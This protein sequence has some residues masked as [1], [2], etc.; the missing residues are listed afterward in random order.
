MPTRKALLFVSVLLP[1]VG[2]GQTITITGGISTYASLTNVT[3]NMSGQCELRVTESN[4]PISGC[5]INLNSPD[6]WL[7]FPNV[8]P[9]VVSTGYLGQVRV[10]GAS[11]VAGSNCRLDQYVMGSVIVPHNPSFRPLTL[12]SGANFTG[13][14]STNFALYTYHTNN[15]LG[16]FNRNIGSFKLKRGYMATFAQNAN[17]TGASR[18]FI[19]QDGDLEVALL[20]AS[21][22]NKPVSFV[23][24]FP[25]RWTA[26]RGWAGGVQP[27]VNPYWNYDWNTGASSTLDTEYA[28]MKWDTNLTWATFSSINSKQASSH[29]LGYNEP[30]KSDQANVPVATAIGQW[31]NFMQSGLRVGAPGVSD[32]SGSGFGKSWLYSFMGQATN[33]GYRVDYVPIHAYCPASSASALMSYLQDAY[34]QTKRPIWLTEFNYQAGWCGGSTPTYEQEATVIGQM[35]DALEAAPY[36]ERYSIYN[37]VG[38]TR[39]MVTSSNTLTPA[40]I[41]YRDKPSN[42]A[43]AQV[44]PEAGHRGIAQLRFEGDTRD[45]SGYLHHGMAAGIPAYT[46]G[47]NGLAVLLE[48]SNSFVQLPASVARSN[49]FSFAAWVRW[50]GGGNWQRIFDFGNDLTHYLFLTP[51]SGSGTLRFAI[52]NGGSE[53]R[54]ET[55][56][57]LAAGQWVHVA[58]TMNGATGALYTNGL[59]A[60]S[61]SVSITPASFS[62]T[63]NYLGKSQ[64]AADPLFSGALDEVQIADYAF[65]TS[66]IRALMTNQPPQFAT[67]FYDLGTATPFVSFGGS[68]AGAASDPDAGDTITYSK[69]T[70]PAWLT[71]SSAGTLSGTPGANDGGTNYFTARATD[72]AGASDFAVLAVYVPITYA[73]GTWTNDGDGDWGEAGNWL[74]GTNANGAGFTANFAAINITADR[75]V[76]LDQSRSIGTLT[77]GDTS[78]AQNWVL[79]SDGSALALD[80][81]SSVSPGIVVNQNTATVALPLDGNNGFTKTGAGTLTLSAANTLSGTIYTDRDN[82]SV[83]DGITRVAHYAALGSVTNI[84]IRNN[85]TGFSRLQ[86]DGSASNITVTAKLNVSCRNNT[87]P[88]IQNVAG[89]NTIAGFV[90]LGVGG[91][92]FN[93]QADS[94]LLVF[95]NTNRYLGDLMGGRS[96]EF[97]GAGDHLVS[98]PILNSTNGAPISLRK[99]GSGTLR[100]NAVNTYTNGT[101]VGG[102]RLL[103]NGTVISNLTVLAGGTLGGTGFVKGPVSVQSG[104]TLAPGDAI[105]NLTISNNLSLAGTALFRLNKT[106]N[107]NDS[108]R[109]TGSVTYGG[110]LAVTNVGGTLVSGDSYR[111]F[112]NGSFAGS[113]G[114][115]NLPPVSP[116]LGWSFN[117][118]NGLLS[119]VTVGPTNPSGLT[120]TAGDAQV[121]L[122]WNALA[123]AASYNVKSAT[124]S[125]GPYSLVANPSATNY[126]HTGLAAGSTYYYVVSGV[127]AGGESG[128]S[129]EA[130]A[131]TWTAFQAWQMAYFGCTNCPQADA[132]ADADGDG[133]DNQAE[134]L[135]GTDPTNTVSAFRVISILPAGDDIVVTWQ[136]GAGKTGA[137][138][139]VDGAYS[140]NFADLSGAI[141]MPGGG[142]TNY[143]DAGAA[144]NT[145]LRFYRVRLVP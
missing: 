5:T 87:V 114:A 12:Y 80:S 106:A 115:M 103:V 86:L 90:Q 134:W 113:F 32:T 110:T 61:G 101:T 83:N 69:A 70:G 71:I 48:G 46:A 17:G 81:G 8:R 34:N 55:A 79:S 104:G 52:A 117:P 53:Q 65:S 24:V 20:S 127:N 97:L 121:A 119:V 22:N 142:V 131:T 43:Y 49:A 50:N 44:V 95:A 123:G 23:R 25:W 40:G 138:Q 21:L 77:F 124:N 135:S 7:L 45:T 28:P 15:V 64:F 122:S 57:A 11:A 76:T 54:V 93:I 42:M 29:A 136:G 26:K 99:W 2:S 4:S 31:P 94:G 14:S 111:L 47:T 105:G 144:T 3:V 109:T 128:N 37:W 85:N 58:F 140:T 78:G 56:G 27:L 16:A 36:V 120:A 88:T 30:D 67:N 68:I 82:S 63:K 116:G 112:N 60:A 35:I 19:A 132:A 91:S 141:V 72:G 89:T 100:L 108:V 102:G 59:L 74:G 51:S 98:G 6:A 126:T 107:T 92:N 1:V 41:L 18:N 66:Q 73:N 33:L 75:T 143:P 13:V 145:L 130:N 96:Y 38:D 84:Q 118:T 139:A 129:A 133:Q 137:V 125:G 10:N 39:A 9:S 62:P